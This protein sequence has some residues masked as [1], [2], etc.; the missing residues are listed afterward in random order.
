MHE[1][2]WRSW[3]SKIK[4][5]SGEIRRILAKSRGRT[6]TIKVDSKFSVK[7]YLDEKNLLRYKLWQTGNSDL[8]V[9]EEYKWTVNQQDDY[10]YAPNSK[11]KPVLQKAAELLKGSPLILTNS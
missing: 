3:R 8:S 10:L 6:S 2:L 5:T 7:F 11:L 9:G 4:V 1:D